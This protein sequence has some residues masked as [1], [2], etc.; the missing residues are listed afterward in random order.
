[1]CTEISLKKFGLSELE[2]TRLRFLRNRRMKSN[3]QTG[4]KGNKWPVKTIRKFAI[5]MSEQQKQSNVKMVDIL[6]NI[7]KNN[8]K[9]LTKKKEING[10]F[11]VAF[12]QCGKMNDV[13]SLFD[14]YNLSQTYLKNLKNKTINDLNMVAYGVLIKQLCDNDQCKH[15]YQILTKYIENN[16]KNKMDKPNLIVFNTIIQGCKMRGQW[17]IA[18]KCLNDIS[19]YKLKIDE[20]TIATYLS[21]CARAIKKASN[22]E[23]P[24]YNKPLEN[25]QNKQ[26]T[27]TIKIIHTHIFYFISFVFSLIP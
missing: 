24:R 15:A 13:S 2:K 6:E 19:R 27:H 17:Q 11:S 12:R 1:M 26:T 18:Q 3:K 20:I 5:E 23:I 21:V 7:L 22:A 4:F 14:C 8:D 25:T 16:N 9:I 10:L